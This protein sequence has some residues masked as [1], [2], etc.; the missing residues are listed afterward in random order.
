M[1]GALGQ[2]VTDAS[3]AVLAAEASSEGNVAEGIV[4]TVE[5]GTAGN[6]DAE[7]GTAGIDGEATVTVL[8]YAVPGICVG[9]FGTTS[10]SSSSSSPSSSSPPSAAVDD[11]ETGY[12]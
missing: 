5:N 1:R 10:C 8:A 12:T 3:G 2:C 9:I 6:E 4:D 11:E 7:K